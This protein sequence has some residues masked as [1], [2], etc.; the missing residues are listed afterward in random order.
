MDLKIIPVVQVIIAALLMWTGAYLFPSLYFYF[1][2]TKTLVI[3]LVVIAII[4]GL[5]AVFSFRNHKTTV[6]PTNPEKA[7]KVVNSGIYAFSRNPMY[8]ALLLVLLAFAFYLSNFITFVVIP[9]FIAYITQ[10]QIKPEERALTSL[11]GQN[12]RQYTK[13]VRRWI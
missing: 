9:L 11:F 10:F 13:K 4:V 3:T 5:T 2:A 1:L 12:Y 8:L 7:S 6:D